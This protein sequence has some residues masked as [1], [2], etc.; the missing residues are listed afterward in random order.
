MSNKT[1]WDSLSIREKADL[2]KLFVDNDIT[3]L[4]QIHSLYNSYQID[5]NQKSYEDWKR[6]IKEYKN[7][8]IDNDKSYDYR[9]FY[10]ENPER[11]YKLL[12]KDPDTHF[13]DKYKTPYHETFSD[14][15]IYSND[16]TKGG[17]WVTHGDINE[18]QHSDFTIEHPEQ[19]NKYI[20]ENEPLGSYATYKNGVVLDP[21]IVISNKYGGPLNYP[22]SNT[23]IPQVRYDDGGPIN[24]NYNIPLIPE[25]IE[26]DNTKLAY[27]IQDTARRIKETENSK[28][29]IKG[30]YNKI[31]N[32]WYPHKSIE[33]GANTIAY[34]IKLSNGTDWAKTALEQGYLTDAQAEKAVTDLAT[35]YM[36]SARTI[37]DKKYGEGEFDKL[38]GKSKSILTDF[39]YNP[40]LQKFPN[41]MNGFYTEDIDKIEQ[42]YKRYSISKNKRGKV[43]K[44][45]LGRNKYIKNDID[46][47]KLGL[48]P[49]KGKDEKYYENN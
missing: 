5:N 37:Y 11:A 43:S 13:T 6:K 18:F 17:H 28:D 31:N 30:G 45:E 8:D 22:F 44:K 26:P 38:S 35:T 27:S 36:D 40:G 34:G 49:I 39:N 24:T 14:E 9:G 16:K 15:S 12:E 2:M 25:W 4:N 19:T 1:K 46:S 42:N 23:P 20:R 10:N 29:N 48:Y 47:L 7:I 33:G 41:L 21:A 3:D 32:R